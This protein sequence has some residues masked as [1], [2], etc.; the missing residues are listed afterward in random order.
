MKVLFT[1]S[2]LLLNSLVNAQNIDQIR[3]YIDKSHNETVRITSCL[4]RYNQGV[5]FNY[6]YKNNSPYGKNALV[7]YDDFYK[8][9]KVT[10]FKENGSETGC[11]LTEGNFIY[12]TDPWKFKYNGNVYR[13]TNSR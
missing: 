2:I 9:Y 12:S 13:L 7:T 8:K 4:G 5:K 6:V 10:F 11:S 1:I 3:S